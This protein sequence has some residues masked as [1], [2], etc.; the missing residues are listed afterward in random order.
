MRPIYFDKKRKI[1]TII[2]GY[3]I[4]AIVAISPILVAVFA[5]W[6]AESNGCTLDEGSVHP[7]I[8]ASADWG[9]ILYTMGVMGWFSLLS[10]PLGFAGLILWTIKVR[11]SLHY[12][13]NCVRF[14]LND[15]SVLYIGDRMFLETHVNQ[16]DSTP[17]LLRVF[18]L[19]KKEEQK[20]KK[21]VEVAVEGLIQRDKLNQ[22]LLVNTRVI[23]NNQPNI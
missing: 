8:I 17:S 11:E 7:C 4:I 22:A 12:S 15:Y 9:N 21:D 3:I 1:P 5:G 10:M 19:N 2:L 13:R 16:K 23:K 20:I 6:I 14:T 18:F